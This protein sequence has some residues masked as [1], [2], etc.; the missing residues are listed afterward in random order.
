MAQ[1]AAHDNGLTE[2]ISFLQK[3][4]RNLT[5]REDLPRKADP[6][7][8]AAFVLGGL[9]QAMTLALLDDPNPD[10]EQLACNVWI[11]IAQSLGLRVGSK[12]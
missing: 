12:S 2:R 9:R 5:A 1:R 8:A 10:A 6:Q 7:I 11:L 3:D 4:A